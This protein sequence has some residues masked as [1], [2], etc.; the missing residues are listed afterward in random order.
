[1]AHEIMADV[2]QQLL[3]A[4]TITNLT[5]FTGSNRLDVANMPIG[6]DGYVDRRTNLVLGNWISATNFISTNG[7]SVFVPASASPEFY[8][9]RFPFVWTWP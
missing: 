8:R 2:A 5:L 7:P 4:A 3:S 6:L 1:M 9:L